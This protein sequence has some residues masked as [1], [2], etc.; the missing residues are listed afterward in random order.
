MEFEQFEQK[1]K[2]FNGYIT[3]PEVRYFENGK[4]KCSF[5]IPLKKNKEDEPTWLNCEAWGRNAEKVGE[6]KK[7]DE[8]LVFGYLYNPKDFPFSSVGAPPLDVTSS[9][10]RI[11]VC[12]PPYT[13]VLVGQRKQEVR[14][15]VPVLSVI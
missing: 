10:A 14:Y 5:A 2:I 7:G 9:Q 8:V 11:I 13:L 4:C 6:L 3:Q 15:L 12:E 1:L